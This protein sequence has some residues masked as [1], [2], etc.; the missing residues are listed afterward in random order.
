MI[1]VKRLYVMLLLLLVPGSGFAGMKVKKETSKQEKKAVEQKKGRKKKAK[2][3]PIVF[4]EKY[5][6]SFYGLEK[7]HP[8]DSKKYGKAFEY[9]KT[10]AGIKESQVFVPDLVTHDELLKVHTERYLESLGESATVASIAEM[11]VLGWVPGC[12]HNMLLQDCLLTPMK[13]AT[14]GTVMAAELALKHGWAINLSGGYHHAKEDSGGGFCF[15]A[16]IPLAIYQVLDNHPEISK[17]LIVDLDAHQGNGHAS[18]CGQGRYEDKVD[19]FDVF[20]EQIYPHDTAAKKF[21]TYKHPVKSGIKD[22]AYLKII[23]EELPEAIEE[24]EPN[25][26]VYNAGTDPLDGDPLGRMEISEKGMIKRD[27]LVFK[28]AREKNIPIVMVLSGGYTK[29]SARLIGKSCH[30][31]LSNVLEIPGIKKST[32][33]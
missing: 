22:K 16:D 7:L 5:D 8:F 20:N 3:L 31:I 32:P 21:I 17:V 29:Q 18:I 11:P 1:F 23:R 2:K 25:L 27:E 4:H 15:F 30:N 28:C 10:H 12:L 19:I 9:L 26:I 33:G 24:S 6:I 14:K 13:Y